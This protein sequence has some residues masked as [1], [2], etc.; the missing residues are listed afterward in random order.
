[1]NQEIMAFK[2]QLADLK[3]QFKELEIEASGQVILIRSLT[4][5]WADTIELNTEQIEKA[6][7]KL[8]EIV[9]KMKELSGKIKE[10]EG[11]ING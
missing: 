10:I 8:H 4:N 9:L 2:G 5:P 6:A 3:Y 11:A 1:M 7:D